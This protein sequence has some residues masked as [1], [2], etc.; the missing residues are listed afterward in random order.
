[1]MTFK[2]FVYGPPIASVLLG[3]ATGP[4]LAAGQLAHTSDAGFPA[5]ILFWGMII[6]LLWSTA[7]RLRARQGPPH[8]DFAEWLAA[9]LGLGALLT[10]LPALT[11][12]YLLTAPLAPG[13][14]W[15][16]WLLFGLWGLPGIGALIYLGGALWAML[17]ATLDRARQPALL[18]LTHTRNDTVAMV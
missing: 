7:L 13:Y 12:S 6:P 14:V 15:Q 8:G 11:L 3:L 2:H 1:M 9:A 18:L 4:F 16:P 10:G 17:Y 5:F